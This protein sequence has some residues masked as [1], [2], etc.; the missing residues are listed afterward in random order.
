MSLKV[1]FGGKGGVGKTTITALLARLAAADAGNRVLAVD[2]D[3]VTNL[4]AALGI[5]E[6]TP[7]KPIAELTE[8]IAERTGA[9]PGSM[10]NFFTLN[11]RVDDIPEKFSVVK[12]RV[13]FLA[14]GTVKKG[15]SGCICPASTI[16]KAL[17]N[18]LILYQ[19]D[20]VFMDMEA[21]VE[22]LGRA[23]SSAVDALVIVVNPG[24]R[25]RA[26]AP[27]LRQLA[28]DIGIRNIVVLGNRVMNAEDE[29]LVRSTLPDCRLLGCIGELEEVVRSDRQGARPF[30]DINDVPPVFRQIL[31]ELQGVK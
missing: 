16:L 6:K 1:A 2:A 12:D 18:H 21:G 31:T 28:E 8:F 14:L 20:M 27:Q 11:P 26:A 4:A 13:R 25:S 23:T 7:V 10:G 15:G 22:H 17:M 9:T 3:P 19:N 24:A 5:D 30:D 29:E